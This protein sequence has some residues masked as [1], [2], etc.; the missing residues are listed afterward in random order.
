MEDALQV[1]ASSGITAADCDKIQRLN[2]DNLCTNTIAGYCRPE[3]TAPVVEAVLFKPQKGRSSY[4]L[5]AQDVRSAD[6]HIRSLP[7]AAAQQAISEKWR[8]ISE[9]EKIRYAS[10]SE[11][12]KRSKS[13]ILKRFASLRAECLQS[14][15]QEENTT[16]SLPSAPAKTTSR[17]RHMTDNAVQSR[18]AAVSKKAATAKP[19]LK[20]NRPAPAARAKQ[21]TG[22]QQQQENRKMKAAED[23]LKQQRGTFFR[24]HWEVI[25]PLLDV[26]DRSLT[27]SLARKIL[28]EP[29]KSDSVEQQRNAE[30]LASVKQP[31]C[32][33]NGRMHPYQLD[34]LRWM[35]KQHDMGVGGILGDEM[36]L[37]K[38]LQVISFL[39][40]HHT[41]HC[42]AH[43]S[44]SSTALIPP[45]YVHIRSDS[46]LLTH[47][48]F[49]HPPPGHLFEYGEKG[50][51]LIVCPLSVLPTWSSELKRWCPMLRATVFHGPESERNFL[52]KQLLLP[53]SFDV[54]ITT[55]E[56][57]VAETGYFTNRFHFR[58][59][60][61]DEAQRIKNETSLV[62]QAVRR[63]RAVTRLLL[64]GTPL[65]VFK[66]S[67]CPPAHTAPS[68]TLPPLTRRS[69]S[70]TL[71]YCPSPLTR[72]I[73]TSC[74]HYSTFSS[75]SY[76]RPPLPSTRPSSMGGRGLA[77]EAEAKWWKA[78]GAMVIV[79]AAAAAAAVQMRIV[80][81]NQ[82]PQ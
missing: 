6:S 48:L 4:F 11:E 18:A 56:T 76:L 70:D 8:S 38:T 29:T 31:K 27:S 69:P 17:L 73:Y 59:A 43:N 3:V 82:R 46:A 61:L 2:N 41:T 32:I 68:L 12:D 77:A 80:R 24:K 74:G 62:G 58:V 49:I 34:G 67:H 26:K 64:T 16:P 52:K 14:L 30:H 44:R 66:Y 5:F 81:S 23:G 57:L 42:T 10:L 37:G 1:I 75:R 45:R 65:Q 21:G 47:S 33:V 50:P 36:G 79:R 51:H 71:S 40:T 63:V 19:A 22:T 39:G 9:Q 15:A 7:A 55:Y 78:V 60:V 28:N 25:A 35:L 72:M 53:D 13:V 20:K 54:L